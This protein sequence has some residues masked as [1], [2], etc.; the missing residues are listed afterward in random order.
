[1]QGLSPNQSR[2]ATWKTFGKPNPEP[3]LLAGNVIAEEAKSLGWEVSGSSQPPY[4]IFM[5]G[6]E[7][8]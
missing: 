4:N 1:M 8:C 2:V 6:G 7:S 5:I 3:Y